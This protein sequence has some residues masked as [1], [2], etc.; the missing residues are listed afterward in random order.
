MDYPGGWICFVRRPARG[1]ANLVQHVNEF[2]KAFEVKE[3]DQM[4][5]EEDFRVRMW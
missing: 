2:Y 5:L 4:F 1:G 3:G